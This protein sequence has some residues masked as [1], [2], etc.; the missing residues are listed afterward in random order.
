MLKLVFTPQEKRV[1]IF[2]L[3]TFLI[4]SGLRLYHFYRLP[5]VVEQLDSLDQVFLARA[6]TLP[7]EN[8]VEQSNGTASVNNADNGDTLVAAG[9][10][11]AT[12]SIDINRASVAELETL[13][14]IGPVLAERII[15]WRKQQG[16]FYTT[17]DL[18]QVNGI[19]R[20]TLERLQARIM[21]EN[22]P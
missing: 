3:A 15:A 20:R 12:A 14:G 11:W 5:S 21:V 17:E 9:K 10:M 6:E 22:K 18:L 7:A 2:I 1:F 8:R 16:S 4:G 19:G 13:P